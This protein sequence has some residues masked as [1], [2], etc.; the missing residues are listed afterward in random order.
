MLVFGSAIGSGNYSRPSG[1]IV[2]FELMKS[3]D[4]YDDF[5][6]ISSSTAINTEVDT[7]GK[8]PKVAKAVYVNI[9]GSSATTE[10][11][12]ALADEASGNRGIWA[13][14]QVANG[15]VANSGW[16]P[17][18]ANGDILWDR[19]ATFNEVYLWY[20]GVQLR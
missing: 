16:V 10:K 12:L 17:C 20:S 9:A 18:D 14:S 19:N 7:G 2:W 1:E 4:N 8:I 3:S 11:Y 15:R 6:G 13:Y 5:D